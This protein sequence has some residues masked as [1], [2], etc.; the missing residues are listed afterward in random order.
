M[1]QHKQIKT[2]LDKTIDNRENIKKGEIGF[3]FIFLFA[4]LLGS[5][6]IFSLGDITEIFL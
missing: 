5:M 3:V 4:A 1:E 2:P 6:I